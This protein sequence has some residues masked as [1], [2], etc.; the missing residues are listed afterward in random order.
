MISLQRKRL[1]KRQAVSGVAAVRKTEAVSRTTQV[2]H[3]T[4]AVGDADVPVVDVAFDATTTAADLPAVQDEVAQVATDSYEAALVAGEAQVSADGKSTV[5]RSTS[6]ATAAGS[7]KEGDQWWQFSGANVLGLWLH[8]GTDWVPQVL[9]NAIIATLDAGKITTGV[10]A[11]DRIG[12]NSI[13]TAKLSATAID[14]MTVTGATVRT[15]ASGARFE[16]TN[17]GLIG[18][19]AA[20]AVTARMTPEAGGISVKSPAG[21]QIT[22]LS[23][24]AFRV[25]KT[26]VTT[27]SEVIVNRNS[28]TSKS[29]AELSGIGANNGESS[30]LPALARATRIVGSGTYPAYGADTV[31]MSARSEEAALGVSH[32]PPGS[33]S[34]VGIDVR[35]GGSAGS[36]YALIEAFEST[37]L[38]MKSNGGIYLNAPRVRFQ[39]DADWVYP[40]LIGGTN[41]VGNEFGFCKLNGVVWLTGRVNSGDAVTIYQMP[42]GFRIKGGADNVRLMDRGGACRVNFKGTGHIEIISGGLVGGG[43]SFAGTSY[44]AA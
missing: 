8:S 42:A 41:I 10:L 1:L 9:T 18:Y 21:D 6:A 26:A 27:E 30:L 13:T 29:N 22:E 44:L 4:V 16:L 7:Y 37:E 15:A 11:A 33:T 20:G 3:S 19:N 34:S 2:A 12:A 5:V 14:G 31:L 17:I 28:V 40:T 36:Y 24:S 43:V 35:A 32:R 39:G 38:E 23:G 25:A